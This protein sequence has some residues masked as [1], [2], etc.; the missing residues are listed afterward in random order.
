MHQ[1]LKQAPHRLT[2]AVDSD[3]DAEGG[4]G[5]LA[6]AAAARGAEAGTV[7]GAGRR[8]FALEY[9]E[10]CNGGQ[11][12]GVLRAARRRRL[13]ADQ[14]APP[15]RGR[16]AVRARGAARPRGG[17]ATQVTR[18]LELRSEFLDATLEPRRRHEALR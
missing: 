10:S 12:M 16:W 5:S 15:G 11:G 7:A 18:P 9:T 8:E 17:R 4:R 2:K 1:L 14:R 13:A 3:H 6:G